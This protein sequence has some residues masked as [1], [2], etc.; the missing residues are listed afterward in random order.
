[1]CET[2]KP[3]GST[4]KVASHLSQKPGGE[5]T[6]DKHLTENYGLLNKLLPGHL[7]MADRG[8]TIHD[9]V[10]LRQA[11]LVI[12]AFTKGKEQLNPIDVEK[13]KGDR[14]CQDPR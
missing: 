11:Q 3:P 9:G 13:N 8:F 4:L 12:P 1:M 5:R 10:A 7:V 6:S 2:N 14:T